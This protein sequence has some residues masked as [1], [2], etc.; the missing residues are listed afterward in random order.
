M[1][2]NLDKECVYITQILQFMVFVL[3]LLVRLPCKVLL[4]TWCLITNI[5]NSTETR[6]TLQHLYWSLSKQR[7]A[8]VATFQP[9]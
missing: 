8:M 1:K 7:S 2:L 4:R 3:L 5:H 9:R 6:R